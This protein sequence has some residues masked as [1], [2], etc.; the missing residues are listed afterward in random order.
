ML[1]RLARI[2]SLSTAV[3]LLLL[4]IAVL[5]SMKG[6]DPAL[7]PAKS[8]EQSV[9]VLVIGH[10]LHSGLII[11]V[12]DVA[13]ANAS[14]GLSAL[15]SLTARFG[16]FDWMEVG[17]GD[18][19]FYRFA[20]S[21]LDVSAAMLLKALFSPGNASV[22]HIVGVQDPLNVSFPK[23]DILQMDLSE[24]GFAALAKSLDQAFLKSGEGAAIDAGPGLYGP[25]RFFEGRH[26][27]GAW[28]V[29]NH[30]VNGLLRV[31][32]LPSNHVLATLP[33]GLFLGLR[34]RAGAVAYSP[35]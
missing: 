5:A 22:V 28:N 30:F 17:W 25:S 35:E 14:Q 7:Y 33:T 2:A 21:L 3:L 1:R 29:C 12:N 8:D 32:G 27:F 4:V 18:A 24:Q 34:W 10:G 31:G 9:R 6:G 11:R 16:A 26:E 15:G 13:R 23:A 20:P 19:N